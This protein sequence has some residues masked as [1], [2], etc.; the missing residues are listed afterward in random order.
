MEQ[1]DLF[2]DADDLPGP[3]RFALLVAPQVPFQTGLP[4][5]VDKAPAD[6]ATPYKARPSNARHLPSSQRTRFTT[7]LWVWIC[8]SRGRLM[9]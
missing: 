6:A 3:A 9:R 1:A 2:V 7:A 5:P 8:T 4:D